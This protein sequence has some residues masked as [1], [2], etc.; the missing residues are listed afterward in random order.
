M[1]KYIIS[2]YSKLKAKENNVVIKPSTNKNKKI[3]VFKNDIKIASI[4][5]IRYDDYSSY[6][7]SKGK[8]Y[9][10]ERRKLYKSVAL[11]IRATTQTAKDSMRL[12]TVLRSSRSKT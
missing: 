2:G 10:D 12:Q 9:A 5:D 7:K 3:D 4:G 6:L 1:S 11:V 8:E